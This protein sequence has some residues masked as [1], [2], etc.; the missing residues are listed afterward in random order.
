MRPVFKVNA[1]ERHGW[2]RI[3]LN[4]LSNWH[5]N[6]QAVFPLSHGTNPV[7]V[8]NQY[9]VPGQPIY[10]SLRNE[11]GEF[12]WNGVVTE[13]KCFWHTDHP[14]IVVTGQGKTA[15]L[16]S[17]PRFR[18]FLKSTLRDMI[19]QVLSPYP[20]TIL[21]RRIGNMPSEKRIPYTVQY[22]ES[23]FGFL[24]RLALEYGI[25]LNWDGRTFN[26]GK[27]ERNVMDLSA[28]NGLES[29]ELSLRVFPLGA[30]WVDYDYRKNEN[31]K[32]ETPKLQ[33][34]DEAAK[35]ENLAAE[36]VYL[37]PLLRSSVQPSGEAML[38]LAGTSESEFHRNRLSTISGRS[39]NPA[40]RP[41]QSIKLNDSLGDKT[42][43]V[44][45]ATHSFAAR[46]SNDEDFV[47]RNNF[48]AIPSSRLIPPFPHPPLQVRAA[49]ESGIVM[50]NNDS[51]KQL[52]RV[53]VQ[54][55]WQEALEKLLKEE[56][57]KRGDLPPRDKIWTPWIRV[58]SLH[59][60][61]GRGIHF[62]PEIGDEVLVAYEYGDPRR[63]FVIGCVQNGIN[64]PA[65][66][67]SHSKNT[68]KG[69]RTK[70]GNEILFCDDENNEEITI[71]TKGKLNLVA[72]E[73]FIGN[74]DSGHPVT[75]LTDIKGSTIKLNC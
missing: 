2:E 54:L 55:R 67:W 12:A 59:G 70:S 75:D 5:D 40:V 6:L 42:W 68:K 48:V 14:S 8:A 9:A 64:K 58:S 26:C 62:L 16:E 28:T 19:E 13:T 11:Y 39:A 15:H 69:I 73:I 25:W 27:P 52:G 57:E 72:K 50:A 56:A 20:D 35:M 21:P 17:P 74:K 44:V 41:S 29:F 32:W 18:S 31:V 24:S 22:G 51:E 49:I 7:T 71:V 46:V 23:D 38:G 33:P 30:Q 3:E 34:N 37:K 36:W 47:Y 43:T 61:E 4:Q 65:G 60:G 66:Y 1:E 45:I 10:V 63:P 53:R